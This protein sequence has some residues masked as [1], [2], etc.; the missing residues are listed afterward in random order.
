M[1]AAR[2]DLLEPERK[3]L[4]QDAAVVGSTFWLGALAALAGGDGEALEAGLHELERKEF[5]R[6][7]RSSA[8]SEDVEYSFRHVLVRDVAHN[9]IPRADRAEKHLAAAAWLESLSRPED[10][11]EK[12]AYHYQAAL[13]LAVAAR[14]DSES[15]AA[16]ARVAFVDAGDRAFSLNAYDAATRYWQAALDLPADDEPR[17]PLLL[18]CGRA[19][20]LGG[21]PADEY[22]EQALEALL[23]EGDDENA[24]EA[25]R[26]LAEHLWLKG[27][28]KSSSKH[29]ENALALVEPLPPS[30]AKAQAI[31]TAARFHMLAAENEEAIRRGAEALA[32]AEELGLD[33]TRASALNS[34]GSA[35]AF[36]RSG[37]GVD[38]LGEAIRIATE[39]SAPFE[40]VRAKGN[41]A[42]QLSHG[43]NI[44]PA[45]ALWREA[46]ADAERFG[47]RT[48]RRWFEAVIVWPAYATGDWDTAWRDADAFLASVEAGNPHYLASSVYGT[49]ALMRLAR[50][51]GQPALSDAGQALELARRVGEPQSVAPALAEH[52]LVSLELGD[53]ATAAQLVDEYL[54]MLH[55]GDLGHGLITAHSI[56]WTAAQLGR[57]EDVISGFR[58][59]DVRWTQAAIAFAGGDLLRA[60]EISAEMGAVS[61]E[62]YVRLIASRTFLGQGRETEA[63]EQ[64][65]L[66]LAFYRG[67]G[68]TRFVRAA[69]ALTALSA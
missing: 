16:R 45:Y 27:E 47:Q 43:G 9:Q 56:A 65:D 53:S 21:G 54:V 3:N 22:L 48:F 5:I 33:E 2:L 42:A 46:L 41:L 18:R 57:S 8:I 37:A 50:D 35:R 4:V 32:M 12:L 24:A 19:F 31:A 23:A 63:L 7:A 62:A 34:M 69:E 17:G 14:L 36:Q 25:E 64:R 10:H 11:S 29:L 49:R 44:E 58:N 66:A 30:P 40:M 52:A 28:S 51:Q 39:A 15:F 1:I 38:E 67:V 26:S 60:A 61:D 13:D 55:G 6:R 59:S 20:M 68:A